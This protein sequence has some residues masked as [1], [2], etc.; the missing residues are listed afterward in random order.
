MK[1]PID[2]I[3]KKKKQK[4][5]K[6]KVKSISLLKEEKDMIVKNIEEHEK[7]IKSI[8]ENLLV[9][10]LSKN[11]SLI[12]VY[13]I[14]YCIY[15]RLM[16][17]PRDAI[18]VIKFSVLLLKLR[19]PYF[20]FVGLIGYLLKEILPCILCCTEKESH[21]FGIFFLELFKILKHWQNKTNWEKECDKTPGFDINIVK[22]SK[23][24]ISLKDL[25]SI[26]KTLNKRILN[27][28]KICLKRDSSQRSWR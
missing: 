28:V 1:E 7:Y 13:I 5:D 16:F 3:N 26:I 2:L 23:K 12:R 27:V 24:T 22:V 4:N 20:N 21:N 14:Q 19:T 15:P 8:C 11:F 18:Y 9:K 17:S 10:I 25:D 6:A